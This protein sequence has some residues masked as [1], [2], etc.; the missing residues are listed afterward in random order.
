MLRHSGLTL[1][2]GSESCRASCEFGQHRAVACRR[3]VDHR[4][5][6]AKFKEV[7]E[8]CRKYDVP[9]I[10]SYTQDPASIGNA[11]LNLETQTLRA[12]LPEDKAELPTNILNTAV[13]PA[14]TAVK[15]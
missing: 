13:Q 1:A 12:K 14:V 3:T 7:P 4:P 8:A 5:K 10:Q 9:M 6:E 11:W 2:K 15:A